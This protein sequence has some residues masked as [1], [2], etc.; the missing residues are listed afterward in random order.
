MHRLTGAALPGAFLVDVFPVLK[1]LPGWLYRPKGEGLNWY[2]KDNAMFNNWL[3]RVKKD[4]VH[5]TY[6]TTS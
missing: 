6:F 4:M 3:D 5:Y 2:K 1:R